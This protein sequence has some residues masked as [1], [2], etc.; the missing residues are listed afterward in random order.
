MDS[1]EDLINLFEEIDEEIEIIEDKEYNI[2]FFRNPLHNLSND[3][4]SEIFLEDNDELLS[5]DE[6]EN[7]EINSES[8]ANE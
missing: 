1:N 2:N 5:S 3:E 8:S 7:F 4:I 6:E